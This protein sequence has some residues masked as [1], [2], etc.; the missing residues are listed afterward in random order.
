MVSPPRCED[1]MLHS[2]RPSAPEKSIGACTRG[3]LGQ[4]R[5]S[6]RA[7]KGV[8]HPKEG[9]GNGHRSRRQRIAGQP[10]G[11][12]QAPPCSL[13]PRKRCSGHRVSGE[14][15]L[16]QGDLHP[17][18]AR[19]GAKGSPMKATAPVAPENGLGWWTDLWWRW[20]DIR[21]GMED[22]LTRRGCLVLAP[23]PWHCSRSG[24]QRQW[25]IL[26]V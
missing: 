6:N 17:L 8:R 25:P 26:A 14:G 24:Q 2:A 19:E 21:E 3:T 11:P 15:E 22:A 10:L 7:S 18:M 16:C 20:R 4:G 12:R 9:Y 23:W 5:Q 13:G 1:S